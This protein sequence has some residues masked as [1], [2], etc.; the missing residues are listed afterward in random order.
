MAENHYR[1]LYQDDEMPMVLRSEEHT[2]QIKS[3]TARALQNEFKKGRIH[4]LSTSTTFEVGVDIGELESVFLRNVPPEPFNY[5]QR[6]GRAGRGDIP[7]LALTYC[8]RN[9]HDL[10]HYQ[11][12]EE[13]I[14]H[15][16]TRAPKLHLKN[17]KI[18]LRHMTAAALSVFFRDD[19]TRFGDMANFVGDWHN[20]VATDNF[21]A[22]CDKNRKDIEDM[23]RAIVPEEMHND[24]GL[25]DGS[26]DWIEHM[27]EPE[28]INGRRSLRSAQD[29]VCDDYVNTDKAYKQF[30]ENEDLGGAKRAQARKE[31]IA[32][33]SVLN[34]LSRKAIIPKYGFPVDVVELDVAMSKR[35]YNSKWSQPDSAKKV[36]LQRDLSQAIAEYA[37]GSKVIAY[38][39]EWESCGV[40][41]VKGKTPRIVDYFYDDNS[42]T[43]EVYDSSYSGTR[44]PR[45]KKYLCPEFGFVT[46]FTSRP[47]EPTGRSR[48]LYTTRPFF[49][50]FIDK[51]KPEEFEISGVKVTKA[52]PGK[53]VV[54]CEGK[55]GKQFYLCMTCGSGFDRGKREHKTPFGFP[56]SHK[57]ERLSLGHEFPTD[58][59]Q[60]KFD[61]LIDE[62]KAYSLAYAVLLGAARSL[63]VPDGDLSVTITGDK[64]SNEYAIVLYD[65]VPGGAGLVANLT[66]SARMKNALER[67][68]ERV[69]GACGCD[70]SC[71]GCLRSYRNQFAHPHLRRKEAL[72]ILD[73]ILDRVEN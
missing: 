3:Q 70:E 15:G 33:E 47:G 55:A 56:C 71:Y 4:L 1:V 61:G 46:S 8:C 63:D 36:S 21:I 40:K 27:T 51:K 22:F 49:H 14:L 11:D 32:T 26:R 34:F 6:V 72:Q 2:A 65:N 19:K 44:S 24:M 35:G 45:S 20:P 23:L 41:I 18:I 52:L 69:N 54:L 58:I 31:T 67:A 25:S 10:Y 13:R 57:L 59:V 38:K 48:R 12:P 62:W 29:D 50:D 39:T 60:M 16:E 43:F 17:P 30:I 28:E 5:T 66:D 53:M 64:D 42:H 37:P 73:A 9:P 7:G 68:Q